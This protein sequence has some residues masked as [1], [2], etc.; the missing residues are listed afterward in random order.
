MNTG[1][2]EFFEIVSVV[3]QDCIL[4]LF[5][6]IIVID[7]VM[8]RAVD[9]P[10]FGIGW[11][12]AKRFTDLDFADDLALIAEDEQICQ[13]MTTQ[14]AA[15]GEMVDLHI[16]YEKSKT[17]RTNQRKK[18][19]P[20]YLGKTELEYV[21]KFTYLGSIIAKDGDVETNVNMRLAKAAA[22]FRRLNNGWKSRSLSQTIKLRLYSAVVVSAA[23]YASETWK[24]TARIQHGLD[25]FHQRN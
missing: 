12:N 22:V 15:H 9:Q 20:I 21:D 17:I 25:V 14:L 1:V 19:Q 11:Q 5:L 3:R 23:I 2:T 16:S 13:E 24:R 8:R 4:S 10:D 18:D 6:F 7:F